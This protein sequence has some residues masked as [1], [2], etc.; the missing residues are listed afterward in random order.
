MRPFDDVRD[1]LHDISQESHNSNDLHT[2]THR[3]QRT[4]APEIV[5][6]RGKSPIQVA[7]AMLRLAAVDGRSI[8]TRCQEGD[9]E[10]IREIVEAEGVQCELWPDAASLVAFHPGSDPPEEGGSIG[11]LTAGTSDRR[12]AAEAELM[13]REMGV[14]GHRYTDVGVAGLHRLVRPLEALIAVDVDALIVIAGMD[15]ALPSVVA[16]LV[17]VPVIAVPTSTGYGFGGDGTAALMT[18][19]QSCAPGVSVVNI[20]NGIGAAITASLIAKRCAAQRRSA[21]D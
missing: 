10:L 17:D 12:V 21:R 14:T 15:G 6:G 13:T 3:R 5:Y 9:I 8:A 18:M 11:I 1:A 20:D 19:L 16:G 7:E 2:D 4:G